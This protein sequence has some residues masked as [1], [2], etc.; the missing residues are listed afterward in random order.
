MY[1]GKHL[2]EFLLKNRA[3]AKAMS[4]YEYDKEKTMRMFREEGYEYGKQHG[5]HTGFEIAI[6]LKF[7]NIIQKRRR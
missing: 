6:M 2:T 3:E 1:P 5:I 4:I 7:R